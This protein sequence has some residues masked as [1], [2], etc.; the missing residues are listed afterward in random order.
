MPRSNQTGDLGDGSVYKTMMA[1]A[2]IILVI[3]GIHVWNVRPQPMVYTHICRN[4]AGT[5]E[6]YGAPTG[7]ID[8]AVNRVIRERN[9]R[10][11]AASGGLKPMNV[12]Y[13]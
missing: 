11:A 4:G 3:T 12:T 1:F 7:T 6:G 8:D 13:I 10:R 2:L 5:T 9:E